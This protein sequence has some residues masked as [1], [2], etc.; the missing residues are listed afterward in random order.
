MW[1]SPNDGG[2]NPNC[3]RIMLALIIVRSIGTSVI[4]REIDF[5]LVRMTMMAMVM[6][7]IMTNS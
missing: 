4:L 2:Q 5:V 3:I 7:V 6:T 1:P